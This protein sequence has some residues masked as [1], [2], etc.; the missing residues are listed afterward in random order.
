M[1]MMMGGNKGGENKTAPNYEEILQNLNKKGGSPMDI[2]GSFQGMN[3][4]NPQTLQIFKLFSEI[5]NG[6][7]KSGG[8][9]QDM[10]FEVLGGSNPQFRQMKTM[11][12]MV[13]NMNGV[14]NT[15]SSDVKTAAAVNQTPDIN[16][17][18]PIRSIA[19]DAIY[20]SMRE[21]FRAKV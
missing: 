19:P 4:I 3:G 9:P 11:M 16:S 7:N 2:L 17:L 1:L 18:N 15:D 5:N 10:L 12:D 21:Y 14:K 13:Q 6:K 20:R 8:V